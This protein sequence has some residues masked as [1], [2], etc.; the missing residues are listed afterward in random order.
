MVEESATK[1]IRNSTIL[2]IP[3]IREAFAHQTFRSYQS[4]AFKPGLPM[5][6]TIQLSS[7]IPGAFNGTGN[8]GTLDFTLSINKMNSYSYYGDSNARTI[9]AQVSSSGALEIEFDAPAND[10][11][12]CASYEDETN[13][14]YVYGLSLIH[15]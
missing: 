7:D 6:H 15:I 11:S 5:K 14:N 13:Y 8:L 12:C 10:L 4:P 2:V 9:S 1:E 3:I